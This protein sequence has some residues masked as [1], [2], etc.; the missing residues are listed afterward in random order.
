MFEG[1][2]KPS[3]YEQPQQLPARGEG[4]DLRRLEIKLTAKT[5]RNALRKMVQGRTPPREQHTRRPE[6]RERHEKKRE[7]KKPEVYTWCKDVP[8]PNL[9][10]KPRYKEVSFP[11][12]QLAERHSD[13]GRAERVL[14]FENI[15]KAVGARY[16]VPSE[17]LLAMAMQESYG[18]P[19]QPNESRDGGAGLIHMQPLLAHKYGL[20]LIDSSTALVDHEHGQKLL[21]AVYAKQY[22]LKEL[23]KK[24]DRFHPIINVDAAARM[25]R[26]Y[27]ERTGSWEEALYRY[28]GRGDYPRK[29]LYYAKLLTSKEYRKEIEDDFNANNKEVSYKKYMEAFATMNRNYELD[30]YKKLPKVQLS[31]D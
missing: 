22:D 23:Q 8:R 19:T 29:I 12:L 13:M 10:Y 21:D 6:H 9:G 28:A 27:Y 5:D 4:V 30:K 26:D 3:E 20:L 31:D 15:T 16:G 25:L 24:D 2:E 14:R 11:G 7:E 17:Y 1:G 18:D